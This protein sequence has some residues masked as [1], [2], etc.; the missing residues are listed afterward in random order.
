MSI[1]VNLCVNSSPKEKLTKT[2]TVGNDY[3]CVLKENTSILR[4]VIQI[5]TA[6]NLTGF[7]YMHIT[8]FGRWYFID[9]IISLNDGRWEVHAHVDV[10]S[11]YDQAIRSNEAVIRR[12]QHK[13]NLY[14]TDPEYKVYNNDQIVTKKFP[15]N[16]FSKTLSFVLTINGS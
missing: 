10:L 9:D 2:V 1:T 13:F 7:N 16:Q 8:D 3:S 14:M 15:T 12:Q 11:T 4:P 6:D 5:A